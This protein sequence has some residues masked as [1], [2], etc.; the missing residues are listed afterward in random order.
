MTKD[1][2]QFT[3]VDQRWSTAV[4]C[5]PLVNCSELFS[6]KKG[7]PPKKIRRNGNTRNLFVSH[8]T[9]TLFTY[10]PL[11]WSEEKGVATVEHRA[12]GKVPTEQSPTVHSIQQGCIPQDSER[13]GHRV[14]RAAIAD[15]SLKKKNEM[16]GLT[17]RSPS[18][19]LSLTKHRDHTRA[20][21]CSCRL[22][23]SN[24]RR[25]QLPS[26]TTVS[27]PH[28]CTQILRF[29]VT[30]TDKITRHKTLFW[31]YH[32]PEDCILMQNDEHDGLGCP[33]NCS[34]CD[35]SEKK[36]V[37]KFVYSYWFDFTKF[38]HIDLIYEKY[39]FDL[40]NKKIQSLGEENVTLKLWWAEGP[41]MLEDT[42]TGRRKNKTEPAVRLN[43]L[44]RMSARTKIL[45]TIWS[46]G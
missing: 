7:H 26:M 3:A 16:V 13:Q 15:L 4:N 42:C 19:H 8:H 25:M 41:V 30:K 10:P 12:S 24:A 21:V 38:I 22:S 35:D 18:R 43:L 31:T 14:K 2:K 17:W 28:L 36:I 44:I 45:S 37:V 1:T 23:L 46:R 11:S 39:L 20:H 6:Y 34:V 27:G 33:R 29:H 9:E 40:Q 5:S 32:R